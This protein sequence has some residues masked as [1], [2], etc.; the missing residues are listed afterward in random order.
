MTEQE[1][2]LRWSE[3]AVEDADLAAELAS[4]QG[5]EEEIFDRFYTSLKF[6][7][8]GLRGVLGA[9]TNRMNIYTVRQ[10]TQGMA[11]HLNDTCKNP[12]A[13]IAYDSRN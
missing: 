10:A 4:I 12:T 13:A 11:N 6:G 8:A 2:F 5:K 3:K 1:L 7:T 9:G